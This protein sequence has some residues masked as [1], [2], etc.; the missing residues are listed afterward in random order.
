MDIDL[1]DVTI[2]VDETLDSSGL[3]QLDSAFRERDGVVSVHVNERHPHLF[4]LEYN[5]VKVNSQDLLEIV[6]FR[7]MHAELVGL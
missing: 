4:I 5:P 1:A 7:G 2:H 3:S 6:K